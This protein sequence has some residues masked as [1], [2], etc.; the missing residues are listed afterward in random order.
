MRALIWGDY[1]ESI[2]YQSGFHLFMTGFDGG[3]GGPHNYAPR[4]ST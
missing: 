1:M 4:H 3:A 2:A